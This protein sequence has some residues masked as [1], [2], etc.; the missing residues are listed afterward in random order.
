MGYQAFL[1][2]GR[3]APGVFEENPYDVPG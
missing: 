3:R 2:R 1:L